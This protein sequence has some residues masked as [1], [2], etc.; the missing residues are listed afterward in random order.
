MK[1]VVSLDSVP[2]FL[3]CLNIHFRYLHVPVSLV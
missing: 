1:D 2:A 3:E